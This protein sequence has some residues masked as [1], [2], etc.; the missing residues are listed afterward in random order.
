MEFSLPLKKDSSD[1]EHV[2]LWGRITT[3][4][5]APPAPSRDYL[6]AMGYSKVWVLPCPPFPLHGSGRLSASVGCG[7]SRLPP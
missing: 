2:Q 1:L 5:S 4:G 6:I 3:Q 7:L